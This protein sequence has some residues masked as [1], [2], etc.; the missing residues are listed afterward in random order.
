LGSAHSSLNNFTA[1][2]DYLHRA[3]DIAKV[4]LPKYHENLGSIYNN[5]A[6]FYVEK[7]ENGQAVEYAKLSLE[8][9]QNCM[10]SDHPSLAN[11]YNSLG[12][13]YASLAEYEE[14]VKNYEAALAIFQNHHSDK[15]LVLASINANLGSSYYRLDQLDRATDYLQQSFTILR[16]IYSENDDN[17]FQF[18]FAYNIFALV[19]SAQGFTEEAE[20]YCQKAFDLRSTELSP[21][22]SDIGISFETFGI[23]HNAQMKYETALIYFHKAEAILHR[24][25]IE[26]P[27]LVRI[28]QAT[29]SVYYNQAQYNNALKYYTKAIELAIKVYPTN[30][31]LMDR[32]KYGLDRVIDHFLSH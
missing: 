26:Y 8:V 32:L 11:A 22:H 6:C 29:G 9:K 7:G 28:F 27:I 1:A 5:I 31:K 21:E 10:P 14:S 4:V 17:H 12:S 20:R 15:S 30:K 2:I 3:L 24:I 16:S 25:N 23:I 13:V 18:A 19:K